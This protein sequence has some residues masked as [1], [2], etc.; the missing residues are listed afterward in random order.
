MKAVRDGAVFGIDISPQTR[1]SGAK[2]F[3]SG[4][5]VIWI[6]FS[7]FTYPFFK[8]R[9]CGYAIGNDGLIVFHAVIVITLRCFK[10]QS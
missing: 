1:L 9:H 10:F 5:P 6:L 3:H 4:D 2:Q 8:F 7:V